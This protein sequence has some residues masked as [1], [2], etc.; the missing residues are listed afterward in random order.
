MDFI[1][2]ASPYKLKQYYTY[3]NVILSRRLEFQIS[4]YSPSTILF[5]FILVISIRF[6]IEEIELE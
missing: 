1:V 3:A 4:R 5:S 2:C 6:A